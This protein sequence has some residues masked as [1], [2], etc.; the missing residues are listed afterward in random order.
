M[1]SEQDILKVLNL[2]SFLEEGDLLLN[3][4]QLRFG[5][6]YSAQLSKSYSNYVQY[7]K[8]LPTDGNSEEELDLEYKP[9]D[10]KVHRKMSYPLLLTFNH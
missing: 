2:F 8:V 6:D 1:H 7:S 9:A 10:I 5:Q 3:R 4:F